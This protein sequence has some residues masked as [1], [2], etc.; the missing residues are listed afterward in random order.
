M[1]RSAHVFTFAF[2]IVFGSAL[3]MAACDA[4][5]DDARTAYRTGKYDDAITIYR[6]LAER[7]SSNIEAWKGLA[8]SFSMVGKYQE[9][10]QALRGAPQSVGVA[11]SNTLGDVLLEQGKT[12]DA[13]QAYRIAVQQRAPDSLTARLNL[14]ILQYQ[15]GEL[16]KALDAFD[17]FIDVYNRG[18]RLNAEEL[19][20]V[21]IAV[22]YLGVRDPQLFKDALKAYDEAA[23]LDPNNETATLLS[24]ELFLEKYDGNQ[25]Q[26]EFQK[27][28]A[29]NPTNPRALLGMALAKEFEGS[30]EAGELAQKA[31]AVNPNLVG[32]HVL[33][34]R[35]G[36][37]TE[38]AQEPQRAAEA[39]LK[40]NPNSLEGLTALAAVQHFRGDRAGFEATRTKILSLHP[41]YAELY[42]VLGD[43]SV[44]HR[45]YAQS[46]AFYRQ[47]IA[48]DTTS[49]RAH[50]NL[51]INLMRQGQ[52]VEGRKSL[53][54]AFKGDPYN[55]WF[56][57]TLDLL[58]TMGRFAE[59]ERGRFRIAADPREAELLLPYV[60]EL[61]EEAYQK[62]AARYKTQLQGPIR[63]ELYN[64]HADF[65]VRTVGLA[66]LG[67]L[68]AAFGNVLVLDS[69][70]AREAGTFNW[71]TTL[72]H[73]LAHSFHLALSDF[74]VPR[75]LTEGLAVLEERRARPGWGDD[76]AP[77][78]I[79]AYKQEKLVPVS[80]LNEGF[81]RPKFP[82]QIGY[83]YFQASLVAE[84]I[85]RDHGFDAILQMLRGYRAGQSTEQVFRTVLKTDPVAFDKV[86]DQYMRQRYARHIAAV[87]ASE[88]REPR[89]EDMG[90]YAVQL[91]MAQ[92]R[93]RDKKY[94]EALPFAQRAKAMFPE[95][96]GANSPY[97]LLAHIYR[98]KGD[99]PKAAAELEALTALDETNY[100]ANLQ[101]AEI[102]ESAGNLRGAAAALDRAV[103]IY[104]MQPVL[105]SKLA[106]L[107]KKTGALHKVVRERQALVAL[108]PVDRA[109]AYYQ[110]AV[111]HLEAGDAASARREVLKALEEAPSFQKAQ[112]LLLRLRGGRP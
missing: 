43:L 55:V 14:A 65:S 112:E 102:L 35:L 42:V 61:G 53:E 92:E 100:E 101:L 93:V 34:A 66:G 110:L 83:S 9:A 28:L 80:R 5:I 57:N 97:V 85:E 12:A 50:G 69:P 105:H 67:A 74:R 40:V 33:M 109:E 4:Q 111:A 41:K 30:P 20:A 39:A 78:F 11:L 62:L 89:M 94:D 75:W 68:G 22:R 58:D 81:I 103:Y 84:L 24:A 79:A 56:K 76:I 99:M 104:P 90:D 45:Q 25:A 23:A 87:K 7:E 91:L 106:D 26:P 51:G 64:S 38:Q 59:T 107:F 18:P 44:T 19:I 71:G 96:A 77:G 54:V 16:D 108:N 60:A 27:V 73:E 15:R 98:E 49:W 72:W 29:R 32:A 46:V 88:Q 6:R 70:S 2:V 8:R 31:L 86:F 52:I 95:Y 10:E 17:T 37:G 3:G 36:L 82:E 48:L 13:E 1:K 63:I 21:G 47:A